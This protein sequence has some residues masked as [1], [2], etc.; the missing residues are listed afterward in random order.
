LLRADALES[1]LLSLGVV[2]CALDGLLPWLREPWLRE[3]WLR[4]GLR[5]PLREP[6]ARCSP[7]HA[8]KASGDARA[9]GGG[10]GMATFARALALPAQA[11]A[12]APAWASSI[13]RLGLAQVD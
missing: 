7:I 12:T 8:A 6:R 2:D 4:G 1:A 11:T 9:S 10:G 3:P 5:E 13:R